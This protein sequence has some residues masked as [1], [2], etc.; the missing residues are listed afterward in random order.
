MIARAKV[1]VYQLIC[2]CLYCYLFKC[3]CVHR[4]IVLLVFICVSVNT[5]VSHIYLVTF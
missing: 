4:S 3:I 5:F 1:G 2:L